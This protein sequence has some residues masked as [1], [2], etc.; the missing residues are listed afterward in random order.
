VT[1]SYWYCPL[2][3]LFPTYQPLCEDFPKLKHP[4]TNVVNT[5]AKLKF[6]RS[7]FLSKHGF[8]EGHRLIDAAFNQAG[9]L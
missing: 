7:D 1:Q 9:L 2:T 6:I 3:T 8:M 5:L 4:M